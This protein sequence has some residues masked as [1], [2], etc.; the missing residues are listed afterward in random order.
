MT[1]LSFPDARASRIAARRRARNP[2]AFLLALVRRGTRRSRAA[3]SGLSD[4]QLL[5]A[6]IDLAV[7]GRGKAAAARPDWSNLQS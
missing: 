4:R 7:A 3:L 1:S 6:G 2:L 5:D